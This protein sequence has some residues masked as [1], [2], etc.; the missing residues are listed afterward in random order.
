MSFNKTPDKA[1]L[2][3]EIALAAIPKKKFHLDSWSSLDQFMDYAAE[4]FGFTLKELL[5]HGYLQIVETQKA[6]VKFLGIK[7]SH[8]IDYLIQRK[9]KST[10]GLTIGWLEE[11]ILDEFKSPQTKQL[12]SIA[13]KVF[14]DI[15]HDKRYIN[16]GK[17]FLYELL[18][19]QKLDRYRVEEKKTLLTKQITVTT[20]D[21]QQENPKERHIYVSESNKQFVQIID[22]IS[23]KLHLFHDLD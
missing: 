2:F 17:I 8:Q 11:K 19:H 7:I 14:S 1:L 10:E 21:V 13:F 3:S 23:K 18:K 6:P 5:N 12:T 4:L 22:I 9:P 15:L 20:N 16:P